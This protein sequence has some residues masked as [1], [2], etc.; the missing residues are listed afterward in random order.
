[1][2][3]IAEQH[4]KLQLAKKG[5]V[6]EKKGEKKESHYAAVGRFHLD[7]QLLIKLRLSE[8]TVVGPSR[9]EDSR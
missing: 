9:V 5:I 1:M 7:L 6:K 2:L 4:S 8:T 3:K